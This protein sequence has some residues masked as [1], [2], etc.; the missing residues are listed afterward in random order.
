M[1]SSLENFI[2]QVN[3]LGLAKTNLFDVEISTPAC[4][5]GSF[6]GS[7]PRLINLFCQSANFPATNIGVR[8]LKIAGPTYKRPYSVDYGGEGI[9]LTFLVDRNMD[10][11]A[12]FDL[13]VSLII[14]PYEYYAYYNEGLTA[15]TTDIRIKQITEITRGQKVYENN[16]EETV[17]PTEDVNN[18]YDIKLEDAFPRNIGMIELDNTAQGSVHKLS[19]NF[20]YRRIIFNNNIYN[21]RKENISGRVSYPNFPDS[22]EREFNR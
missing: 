1:S 8:E 5:A 9:T 6:V 11:K 20:A 17:T 19:V 2:S 15:Y 16:G 14:N 12:Y 22:S 18:F 21:A 13:W 3:K 10:L 4:I 7:I